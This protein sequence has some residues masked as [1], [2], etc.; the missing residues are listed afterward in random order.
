MNS[1]NQEIVRLDHDCYL[2]L[3][4]LKLYKNGLIIHFSPIQTL[5]LKCLSHKLG[6]PVSNEEII[7]Y[8]WGNYQSIDC[9]GLYV[10]IYRIRK[11]LEDRPKTPKYLLSVRGYGYVL[12]SRIPQAQHQLNPP[13]LS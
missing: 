12:F 4:R 10:Y 8:V 11:R 3:S 9:N 13:S 7:Q 6:S 5:I 1:T 2:E